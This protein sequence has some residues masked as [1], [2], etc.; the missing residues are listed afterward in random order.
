MFFVETLGPALT[1][2]S[3]A[4]MFKFVKR[5]LGGRTTASYDE[6]RE[7]VGEFLVRD[8]SRMSADAA[9]QYLARQGRLAMQD[10]RTFRIAA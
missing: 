5:K 3:G 7:A 8:G 1:A 2:T 4:A 10:A 9:I 6:L